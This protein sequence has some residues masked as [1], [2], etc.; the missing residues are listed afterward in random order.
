MSKAR[1]LTLYNLLKYITSTNKHLP[2]GCKK[3]VNENKSLKRRGFGLA[4]WLHVTSM[5]AYFVGTSGRARLAWTEG[6]FLAAPGLDSAAVLQ[7]LWLEGC[8]IAET[9]IKQK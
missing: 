6:T 2:G 3:K 8:S 9:E 4:R 7:F 1:F 5:G